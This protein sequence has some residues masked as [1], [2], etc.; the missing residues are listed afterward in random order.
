MMS[1]S[2]DERTMIK[3][4]CVWALMHAAIRKFI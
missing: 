1:G 3:S 2:A 4:G